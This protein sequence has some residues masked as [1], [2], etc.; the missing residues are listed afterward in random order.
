M[1]AFVAF[2]FFEVFVLG[3][4]LRGYLRYE[5]SVVF[6]SP[7]WRDYFF[8]GRTAWTSISASMVGPTRP[9]TCMVTRAGLFSSAP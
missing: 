4:P 8:A 6:R 7:V 5:P 2:V 3:R 9:A 1:S